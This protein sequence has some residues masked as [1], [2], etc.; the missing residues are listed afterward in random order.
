[1]ALAMGSQISSLAYPL[2]LQPV[3]PIL[4]VI[5]GSMVLFSIMLLLDHNG[6]LLNFII[7]CIT[8][9][10]FLEDE[11]GTLTSTTME[12]TRSTDSTT[13]DR[14]IDHDNDDDDDDLDELSSGSDAISPPPDNPNDND[15]AG[16]PSESEVDPID[17]PST[18]STLSPV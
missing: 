2:P 15:K 17:N 7:H 9:K 10:P 1:V 8:K 18:E 13:N 6:G 3:D 4:H 16:T 5:G 14:E 11:D 12:G